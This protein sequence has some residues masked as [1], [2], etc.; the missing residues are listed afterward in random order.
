MRYGDGIEFGSD[1]SE[2]N[3]WKKIQACTRFEP[4]TSPTELTRQL[5]TGY[6]VGS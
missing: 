6:Y 4:M 3:A 5:G 2:I 1:L